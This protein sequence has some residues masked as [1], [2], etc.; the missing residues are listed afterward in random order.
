V[1][2]LYIVP[3]SHETALY[4]V[5]QGALA[6]VVKH[7]RARVLKVTVGEVRGPPCW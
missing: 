3:P 5:V 7:A 6:N 4:R 2:K 1:L